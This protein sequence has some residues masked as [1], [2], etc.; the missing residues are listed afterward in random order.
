MKKYIFFIIIFFLSVLNTF[1]QTTQDTIYPKRVFITTKIYKDGIKLSTQRV[2]DIFMFKGTEQSLIK[3]KWS[4]ILKPIGP[5][6]TIGG[7]GLAY[8]ALKGKDATS[9]VDGKVVEYK[10]RSLPKLLI[11]IGL[12]AGGLSMIESSNELA[13]HAVDIYNS[14]ERKK[15]KVS[16]INNIQFGLT[17]SHLIGFNLNLN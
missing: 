2:T 15:K 11:G 8:V 3:Y 6:V 16:V 1:A 5:V 12:V 13:Q 10:I 9:I 7:I 4:N 17:D 14:K